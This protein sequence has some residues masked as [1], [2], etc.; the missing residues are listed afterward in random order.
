MRR[1]SRRFVCFEWLD[2]IR[3]VQRFQRRII[4]R[5][6]EQQGRSLQLRRA[7]RG[8]RCR[9]RGESSPH[10]LGAD[11]CIA[12]IAFV[13]QRHGCNRGSGVSLRALRGA[14]ETLVHCGVGC[15]ERCRLQQRADLAVARQLARCSCEAELNLT[16]RNTE[17]SR[18][19]FLARDERR[20]G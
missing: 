4:G 13:G 9:A 5:I 8:F 3:R 10:Y 18:T 1:T 14:S 20:T 7:G 12:R 2:R 15:V 17:F 16:R 19:L 11:D 6:A